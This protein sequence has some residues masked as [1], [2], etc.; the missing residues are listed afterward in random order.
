M[1]IS[2][3]LNT[4]NRIQY[5]KNFINSVVSTCFHHNQVEILLGVDID[6]EETVNFNV[7]H[8][9]EE[10]GINISKF[11]SLRRPNLVS[12]LNYLASKSLGKYLWVLNDDCVL[13]TKN[14]DKIIEEFLQEEKPIYG[15][16]SDDSCDK[17]GSRQYSSFPIINRRAYEVLGFVMDERFNSLGSDVA[18][19]RVFNSVGRVV[20]LPIQVSHLLHQRIDQVV[21][22]D[23]TA[24][25]MRKTANHYT[26][27]PWQIDISN[28]VKKLANAIN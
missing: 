5:L 16:T 9:H 20:N 25:D 4:R 27:D 6:D 21:N 10:C 3:I 22:P 11:I 23:K 7:D 24:V 18:L 17:V 12:N 15:A 28:D 19:W 14:W 26:L 8:W 2:L 1:K 13:Q